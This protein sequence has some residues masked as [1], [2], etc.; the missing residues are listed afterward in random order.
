MHVSIVL[1]C[2]FKVI[3]I[4]T[5]QHMHCM[6]GEADNSRFVSMHVYMHLAFKELTAPCPAPSLLLPAPRGVGKGQGRGRL[7]PCPGEGAIRA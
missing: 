7:M 1:V 3:L 6:N 2:I 4:N 5:I